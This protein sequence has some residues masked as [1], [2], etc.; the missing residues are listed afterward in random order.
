MVGV[1]GAGAW[2]T[3]VANLLA[4]KG[5]Q[6]CLWCR[7][8]EVKESVERE[9]QNNLFLPGVKLSENI[10]PT[11]N[12]K[13]L[14]DCS[15]LVNAVPVQF[16]RQVWDGFDFKCDYLVNLSKGIEVKTGERVSEIFKDLGIDR[17]VIL[18]GPSFAKEVAL[19][20]PT[21]VTVASDSEELAVSARELFS[22]SCFRVYSH[23]DVVGVEIAGALKNVIAIAAGISDGLGLGLNARASLINRGLVEIARFGV[24]FGAQEKTFWGLA[25]MGDLVLTCTGDLSRNRRLGLE[26]GRGRKFEEIVA[27]S[28]SVFEGSETVKAVKKLADEKGIDMPI[29]FEVYNILVKGKDPLLSVRHLLERELKFEFH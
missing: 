4:K 11:N 7:E 6:V 23:T 18:S 3:T 12:L 14:E 10:K 5:L 22:T 28:R 24:A 9:K 13:E 8:K 25:G 26:I 15:V 2:G 20:K 21:A 1:V 27:S 16:I 17:Y 19:E 29:S